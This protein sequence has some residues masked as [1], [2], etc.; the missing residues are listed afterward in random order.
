MR[1]F[2]W[3]L[4]AA[5]A[6]LVVLIVLATLQYRWL[7]DVSQAERERMRAS[8]RSRATDFAQ[9]FD[10][11]LSRAYT[12]FHVDGDQ[13]ADP[14]ATLTAAQARWQ[15]A[16]ASPAVV[17][18]VYLLDRKSPDNLRQFDLDRHELDA[19]A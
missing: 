3:Q 14:V 5:A 4:P 15:S 10:T 9:A 7:G 17:R 18:A 16:A 19:V 2:S 11:E 13:L 8:L 6:M 12:A 1:R